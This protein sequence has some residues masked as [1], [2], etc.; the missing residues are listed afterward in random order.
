MERY[1]RFNNQS[2]RFHHHSSC[3]N[4]LLSW[5]LIFA[6]KGEC[7][8]LGQSAVPGRSWPHIVEQ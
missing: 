5:T 1:L 4:I 7:S 3:G 8:Q 6:T 2:I